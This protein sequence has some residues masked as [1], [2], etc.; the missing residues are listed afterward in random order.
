M[1]PHSPTKE[2]P[3][4]CL[5]KILATAILYSKRPICIDIRHPT[6]CGFDRVLYN[7]SVLLPNIRHSIQ[8]PY[9]KFEPRIKE[10]PFRHGPVIP[11]HD[12]HSTLDQGRYNPY[13]AHFWI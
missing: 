5:V 2:V 11:H 3:H 12:G 6:L 1:R 8:A 10:H 7:H 13:L 9:F 4:E